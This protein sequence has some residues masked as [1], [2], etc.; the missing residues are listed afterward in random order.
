MRCPLS[1]GIQGD[2]RQPKVPKF[3]FALSRVLVL[4]L[5]SIRSN[6]TKRRY[7]GQELAVSKANGE[8]RS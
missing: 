3:A 1:R 8:T 7:R 4:S 6:G 5:S 2:S